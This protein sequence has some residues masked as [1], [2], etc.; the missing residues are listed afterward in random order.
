MKRG[1]R[2]VRRQ[3]LLQWKPL[4][5]AQLC[6]VLLDVLLERCK[7]GAR[8][9]ARG[10][11]PLPINFDT[12]RPTCQSPP[13]SEPPLLSKRFCPSF[14][15][16]TGYP[17]AGAE[18][19]HGPAAAMI[20][21]RIASI[22]GDHQL[23][24]AAWRVRASFAQYLDRASAV[25]SFVKVTCLLVVAGRKPHPDATL[26]LHDRAT[27]ATS[28]TTGLSD[29]LLVNKSRH[30]VVLGDEFSPHLTRASQRRMAC[31]HAE[32]FHTQNLQGA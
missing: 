14:K 29:D 10:I 1:W 17:P 2:L 18:E 15:Q 24:G 5:V 3:I 27:S 6:H 22:R 16:I 4:L 28:D 20:K 32:P 13:E 23:L 12:V 9:S 25:C 19:D 31:A 30:G 11:V 8:R 21:F 7:V 26:Q